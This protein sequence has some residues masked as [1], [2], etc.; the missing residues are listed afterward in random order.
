MCGLAGVIRAKKAA[1]L[2]AIILH[3][4]QHRAVDYAGIVSSDGV[5]LPR[6]RGPGFVS[7]V[8]TGEMLDRLHGK[9]AIGHIRY[10]T[11]DDD[12]TRDNIQPIKGIFHGRE[13]AVAHNGNLTNLKE[14][15]KLI[16]SELRSTSMDTEYILR[17]L[18]AEESDNIEVAL[19]NVLRLLKGSFELLVLL[20]DRMIAVRDPQGSH[21][22]AVGRCGESYFISSET[23]ALPSVDAEYL[24]DIEPGTFMTFK[25]DGYPESTRYAKA[26]KKQCVFELIY[27]GHPAS[28][29]FGESV[30]RF[31]MRLGVELETIL[32]VEGADIVVGV[33][34]SANL[35][36]KGFG[37][38]GRSGEDFTA[39]Y[40][41]HNG[42]RTFIAATQA[43]R[44]EKVVKK[45]TFAAEEV[46]GKTVVLIDDSIVRGTTLKIVIAILMR[47]GAKEVHVRIAS[48]PFRHPCRYG[49]NTKSYEELIANK[50][51][52]EEICEEIG[53]TSLKYLPMSALHK[54][55]KTP[56]EFCFACMDG[57][58]W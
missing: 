45:F 50:K 10:P 38:S 31:R 12:P 16:P 28:F 14:L 23:C 41:H 44:E 3:H 33:P 2:A 51:T 25:E 39:I 8:F 30:G 4:D 17:L 36:A 58:F 9:T 13:I 15:A 32:G 48:P 35:M 47:M 49:I 54:L 52:D 7:D 40:R 21:P 18:E 57:K 53:A 20:P 37:K 34:D 42:D 27:Y 29:I 55:V 19:P 11:V 22:L 5:Y 26:E 24:G 6:E 1:E 43:L 56:D 46:K